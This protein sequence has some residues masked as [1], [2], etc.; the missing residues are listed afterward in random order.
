MR[1]TYIPHDTSI[2]REPHLLTLLLLQFP[3]T[4]SPFFVP[5]QLFGRHDRQPGLGL[6]PFKEGNCNAISYTS[7]EAAARGHF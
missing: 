6:D 1:I 4:L 7:H 5:E 3:P 2:S